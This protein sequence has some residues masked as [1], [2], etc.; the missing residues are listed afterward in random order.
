M[1][2]TGKYAGHGADDGAAARHEAPSQSTSGDLG[3]ARG[4]GAGLE[5]GATIR[6]DDSPADEGHDDALEHNDAPESVELVPVPAGETTSG[7]TVDA[8]VGRVVEI[9]EDGRSQ[10]AVMPTAYRVQGSRP[11]TPGDGKANEVRAAAPST[12]ETDPNAR[13]E[14]DLATEPP[15]DAGSSEVPPTTEHAG[16]LEAPLA[17]QD[18][19]KPLD[20]LDGVATTENEQD[21]ELLVKLPNE[22]PYREVLMAEHVEGFAASSGQNGDET[23]R[24]VL[25]GPVA[26]T[27]NGQDPGSED[28]SVV[29]TQRSVSVE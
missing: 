1:S 4:D 29:E 23:P 17:P 13:A 16:G 8:D 14:D 19:G 12:A 24:E 15:N 28:S 3:D 18:D 7:N 6:A 11:P 5:E 27:E 21:A 10:E 20:V 26:G 22:P 2:T 25:D 9:P